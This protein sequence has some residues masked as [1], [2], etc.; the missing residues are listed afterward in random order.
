LIIFVADKA[1][2]YVFMYMCIHH[3]EERHR[4]NIHCLF[5]TF[6]ALLFFLMKLC[7]LAFVTGN[8]EA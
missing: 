8:L 6:F 1:A 3:F 2:I 5:F 4:S 7:L